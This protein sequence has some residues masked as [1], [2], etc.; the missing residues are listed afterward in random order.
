MTALCAM[1]HD[2]P[3]Q[4]LDGI[5]VCGWHRRHTE[6]AV[7]EAPAQYAALERRLI[8]S[9]SGLTGMPTG[10]RDPG[11]RLDHRVAQHRTDLHNTLATWARVAVEERGMTPPPDTMPAIAAFIVAQLD[12]FLAHAGTRQFVNDMLDNRDTARRLLDPNKVRSFDVAPCPEPDCDGTLVA[13][14]RP[15]DSLL[16]H[17][18]TCDV[19][20]L[21]DD[22]APVHY[23]PADR[24]LRLGRR[25]KGSA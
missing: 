22:G 9:G 7:A 25:I 17:D 16:P 24:W 18:V 21:D 11:I 10:S 3:R 19:S 14:I 8:A 5:H 20:P 2:K 13:R 12:W 23:W 1:D 6:Q 15:L 4:A